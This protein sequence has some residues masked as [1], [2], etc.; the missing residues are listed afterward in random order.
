M[1]PGK[2]LCAAAK[3]PA[4]AVKQAIAAFMSAAPR[5]N[6]LPS[7]ICAPNGSTVQPATSP[8]GTTSVCPAKQKLG[9]AVP[10]RA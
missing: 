4:A 10:S 1:E 3:R 2:S 7:M 8:T 9:S 5:P 6:R